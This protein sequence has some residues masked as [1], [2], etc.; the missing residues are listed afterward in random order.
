[1]IFCENE[2]DA[3]YL[4]LAFSLLKDRSFVIAAVMQRLGESNFKYVQEKLNLAENCILEAFLGLNATWCNTV[5][6]W[7]FREKL[8]K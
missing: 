2:F 7:T 1:M 6:E 4:R 8:R 5:T 3:A